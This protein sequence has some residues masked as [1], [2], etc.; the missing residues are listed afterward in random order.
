MHKN[1][2]KKIHPRVIVNILIE[3][4]SA[5]NTVKYKFDQYLGDPIN[6]VRIF[7]D[8][9]VD[10]IIISSKTA[11]KKGIDLELLNDIA[12][13]ARFPISYVGGIK[14]IDNAAEIIKLGYE[15]ISLCSSYRPSLL[16]EISDR[17]GSSSVSVSIDLKKDFFG[18]YKKQ[19]VSQV[20]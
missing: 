8:K 11:S 10:E 3:N 19:F 17:F 6:L 9:E 2:L 5:I 12:S 4:S 1:R 13:N 14:S 20:K 18:N 15:K 16:K 7:N